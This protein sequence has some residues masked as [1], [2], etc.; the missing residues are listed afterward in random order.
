MHM[1]AL[2]TVWYDFVKMRTLVTDGRV[3][4][5]IRSRGTAARPSWGVLWERPLP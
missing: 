5:P 4:T 1:A 3:V 2:Y